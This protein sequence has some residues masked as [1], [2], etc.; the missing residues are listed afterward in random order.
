MIIILISIL[1]SG[2]A[3][4][5]VS[6]VTG[7]IYNDVKAP[8]AVTEFDEGSKVGTATAT[9]ILGLVATGDASIK[10]AMENAGITK[11]QHVD[12]RSKSI[13][14]IYAEFTVI[15]YGR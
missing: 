5:S 13:L 6:P 9:S 8:L 1:L 11:I 15:V 7:F 10:T 3:A 14:G 12:F 2:C 4:Y